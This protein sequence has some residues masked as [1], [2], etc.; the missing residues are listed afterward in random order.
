MPT[1]EELKLIFYAM[2]YP[3]LI[4]KFM[5]EWASSELFVSDNKNH[6][7]IPCAFFDEMKI[8]TL[9]EKDFFY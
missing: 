4:D 1:P 3:R 7:L 8:L 2:C 5:K 9:D 6:I